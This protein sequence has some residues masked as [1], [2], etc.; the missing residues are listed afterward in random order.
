MKYYRFLPYNLSAAVVWAVAYSLVGYVFGQ[1]WDELLAIAKSLGYGV[2]AIVA[3]LL[4]A[5]VLRRRWSGNNPQSGGSR[6][7]PTGCGFRER[8]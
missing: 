4:L 8:I 6:T 5:Y 7:A 3:L 2:I 1:Y